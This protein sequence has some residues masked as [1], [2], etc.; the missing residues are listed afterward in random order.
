MKDPFRNLAVIFN[1]GDGVLE[2]ILDGQRQGGA[3]RLPVERPG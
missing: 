1:E 2:E 3:P